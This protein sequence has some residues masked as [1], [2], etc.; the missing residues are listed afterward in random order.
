MAFGD[1]IYV[2][3]SIGGGAPTKG[4]FLVDYFAGQAMITLLTNG[5]RIHLVPDEAYR[6]AVGMMVERARR[7]VD[8]TGGGGLDSQIG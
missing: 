7:M 1:E 4:M 3:P 8:I 2:F 6:V 5:N